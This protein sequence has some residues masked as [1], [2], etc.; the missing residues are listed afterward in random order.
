[1]IKKIYSISIIT[2]SIILQTNAQVICD[3]FDKDLINYIYYNFTDP[4]NNWSDCEAFNF[5]VNSGNLAFL[6]ANG[7]TSTVFY[8]LGIEKDLGGIIENK[9]YNVS[10]NIAKYYDNL[11]GVNYSDFKELYI[12]SKNGT[13]V[14][15]ST[16]EPT[17]TGEWYEWSGNYTP[18]AEDIG[19][20]FKFKA[21]FD[22]QG[23]HSIAI[24]GPVSIDTS[25]SKQISQSVCDFYIS[26]SGKLIEQSGI[27]SDTVFNTC[28][29]DSIFTIDLI[30]NKSSS[31]AITDT[32]C[33]SYTSPSGKIWKEEGNYLDTIP[34]HFG[35]DSIIY[36]NLIFDCINSIL[37]Y[38]A[39]PISIYP[40]PSNEFIFIDLSRYY[41]DIN[42]EL[43]S[44]S[45]Q[46]ITKQNFQCVNQINYRFDVPR[47]IYI[48]KLLNSVGLISVN[49][50]IKE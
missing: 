35:C 2:I 20:S 49:K 11:T 14:W 40:N 29:C 36:I 15:N 25:C 1:M 42:L 13:M 3:S 38:S 21:L 27:Y 22:L 4:E 19:K 47:G 18:S 48:L 6:S 50:I 34:N 33:G 5:N 32:A 9:T 31:N 24:D 8:D 16:P 39:S 26:P 45:G 10:F 30:V 28:E 46:I 41:S 23:K 12:G 37:D 44:V 17:I 7:N 43:S